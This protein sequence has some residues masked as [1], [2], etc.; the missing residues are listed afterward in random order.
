MFLLTRDISYIA[1]SHISENLV[2]E[3][4]KNS[5]CVNILK[6]LKHKTYE[7]HIRPQICKI[8]LKLDYYPIIFVGFGL[9]GGLS[10][11]KFQIRL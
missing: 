7:N 2:E 6:H 8:Y 1:L 3:R 4:G 11:H 9:I 10:R 5:T